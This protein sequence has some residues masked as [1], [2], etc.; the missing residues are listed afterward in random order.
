[1]QLVVDA[2]FYSCKC[3]AFQ[4]WWVIWI[5]SK[6]SH[7]VNCVHFPFV[8][9]SCW[10]LIQL[11]IFCFYLI[12]LNSSEVCFLFVSYMI[13]GLIQDACTLSIFWY[14]SSSTQKRGHRIQSITWKML[15]FDV[16]QY[17]CLYIDNWNLLI[18]NSALYCCDIIVFFFEDWPCKIISMHKVAFLSTHDNDDF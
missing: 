4:L 10:N 3:I 14:V 12:H 1:M 2:S 6:R 5:S 17:Q 16:M 7:T 13:W 8:G 18:F 15:L 9:Y 11:W